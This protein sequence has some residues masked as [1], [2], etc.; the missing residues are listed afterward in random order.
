[1]NEKKDKE[2]RLNIRIMIALVIVLLIGIIVRR[3][4]IA[5]ELKATFDNMFPTAADT[6][7]NR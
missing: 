4:F 3:D 2:S 7:N 6:T 5:S 1:M